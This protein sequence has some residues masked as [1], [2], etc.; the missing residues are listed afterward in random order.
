MTKHDTIDTIEAATHA[1]SPLSLRN[2]RW[3]LPDHDPD[4]VDALIHAGAPEALAPILAA[5]GHAPGDI[6]TFLAPAIRD[7]LPNPSIFLDMDPL[8]D[9]IAAAIMSGEKITIWT[10]YDVDGATSAA[11]MGRFLRAC[12]V[13]DLT[14]H[15]PDR[16]TDGYGPNPDGIA[17]IAGDGTDLLIIL[18]SGTAAFEPLAHGRALGLD[19][20]VVDHHAA[21]ETLPPALALVNPN[22]LD[23]PAG[24]G[25][26]CAAGMTFIALVAINLRLRTAGHFDGR[27]DIAA[28]DLMSYL[29]LVALGTVC[30]VVPLTGLNRAFVAKGLPILSRRQSPGIA[31]LAEAAGCAEALTARDCGFGLGPRINAGG[32]IG[33]SRSGTDL[34]LETDKSEA[35]RQA[36]T[37][38]RLNRERQEM[39][40]KCTEDALS[41]VADFE[42]GV[43]RRLALA[44]VDAHEGIV[45]ISASRLK[46][47]VDA[48]SF[49][50]APADGGLLKG[51]GRSVTGFDI[52]AAIIKARNAGILVKGG[53]HA[54][55]G[56][57][58]LAEDKLD[59]F[60]AFMDA[61]IAASDYAANGVVARADAVYGLDAVT[62]DTV[63][64][65]ETLRPFGMGNPAP[66]MLVR[67]VR[68]AEFRILKEKHVKCRLEDAVMG[69]DGPRMDALIW[70]AAGTPL[71]TALAERVGACVDVLGA[72]EINTWND[73]S[74]VQMKM[75]D[76]RD[77]APL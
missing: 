3:I 23:Q 51:S 38:D 54:M 52:G 72:L 47:A 22:R 42:P 5:R 12:G 1:E 77:A 68:I 53:G 73:R 10:D 39:E 31:A 65:L 16:I 2:R 43:T 35:A 9:R 57:V 36:E 33:I 13:S 19:I 4:A 45:G 29:D 25:H 8:A 49:V 32:R 34:L 63:A 17:A 6:D 71:G 58:T 26:V 55:A 14:I 69:R 41:Q 24:Y 76:V 50:L 37:L 75:E 56:G 64:A 44:V 11:L 59:A 7:L 60:R 66:R 21:E 61:E 30:D 74:S 40:R 28:P 27:A 20:V 46:D 70:N 48:P 67:N 15:V 62:L 18:D